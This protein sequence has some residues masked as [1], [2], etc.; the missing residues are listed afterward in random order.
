[1]DL[2]PGK[3]LVFVTIVITVVVETKEN[4]LILIPQKLKIEYF[5]CF[6]N[7][8]KPCPHGFMLERG[9][10]CDHGAIQVLIRRKGMTICKNIGPHTP[11]NQEIARIY[12]ADRLKEIRN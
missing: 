4:G 9:L 12:L 3:E 6:N 2:A 10:R 11:D 1:M 7:M 8:K 5:G